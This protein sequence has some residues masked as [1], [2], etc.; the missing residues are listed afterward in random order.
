M[1]R[2]REFDTDAA[3]ARAMDVFWCHGFEGT[4]IQD[5]VE[6]TGVQRGSLYAAFGNKEGLYL[7]VL[8]RYREDLARPM[9]DALA[10]VGDVRTLVRDGVAGL[11]GTSGARR[12][13]SGVP[14]GQRRHRTPRARPRRWRA[15]SGTPSPRSRTL[16]PRP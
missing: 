3:L 4:S 5:V 10:G 11:G 12:A 16:W 6:A 7:A 2:T 13:A 14:H 1:A 15:G 9:L 8:D